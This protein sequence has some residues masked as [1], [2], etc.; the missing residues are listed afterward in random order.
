MFSWKADLTY[1]FLIGALPTGNGSTDDAIV[2]HELNQAVF[3][4]D[5]TAKKENRL[6]YSG[7]G[8]A[9]SKIILCLII[10]NTHNFHRRK[11]P[12]SYTPCH[13]FPLHVEKL[14]FL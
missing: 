2:W 11:R 10:H 14:G 9:W 8:V 13:T 7:G 1:G 5:H 12:L 3:T 6:D 4:A